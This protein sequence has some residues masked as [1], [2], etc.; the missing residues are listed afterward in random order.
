[1]ALVVG[2]RVG[3]AVA[4]GTVAASIVVLVSGMGV[5]ARR[6]RMHLVRV[7]VEGLSFVWL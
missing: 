6:V 5:S 1:M 4:I 7:Q 2:T 3:I